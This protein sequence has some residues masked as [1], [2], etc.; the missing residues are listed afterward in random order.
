VAK[1]YILELVELTDTMVVEVVLV[2]VV[3]PHTLVEIMDYLKKLQSM[4][5]I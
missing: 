1:Q 2:L 4:I 5:Y 3:E